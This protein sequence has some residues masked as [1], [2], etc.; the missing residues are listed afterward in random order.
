MGDA[1]VSYPF[2]IA[3]DFDGVIHSYDKGWGDGSIYGKPLPECKRSLEKL[4]KLGAKII[5]HSTRAVDRIV[6]GERSVG[7]Y[8]E[9]AD[10]LDHHEIPYD[11][12]WT[13]QGKPFA[14]VY[15]DD[16]AMKFEN[17]H[18]EASF[19]DVEIRRWN[20]RMEKPKDE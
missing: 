17:W 2:T 5:I 1:M 7:Q 8:A 3:V 20:S 11:E 6:C 16:R 19:L 13:G 18:R 9:M 15:L 12:V 4:R 10:W 14:H